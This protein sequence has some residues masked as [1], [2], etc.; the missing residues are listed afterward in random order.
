MFLVKK[1]FE[2]R[3]SRSGFN[4]GKGQDIAFFFA[5]NLK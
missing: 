4:A 3:K 1:L 5:K 2:H